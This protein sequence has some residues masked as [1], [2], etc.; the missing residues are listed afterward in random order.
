MVG[1]SKAALLCSVH[2]SRQANHSTRGDY[3]G[4]PNGSTDANY[5]DGTKCS[6]QAKGSTGTNYQGGTKDLIILVFCVDLLLR[7]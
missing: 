7:D 3:S 1:S 2:N 5:S 6:G 4:G